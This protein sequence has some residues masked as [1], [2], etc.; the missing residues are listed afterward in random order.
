MIKDNGKAVYTLT[1]KDLQIRHHYHYD[2]LKLY[3]IS[4]SQDMTE[5]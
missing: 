3:P 5:Y 1:R 4:T 2:I